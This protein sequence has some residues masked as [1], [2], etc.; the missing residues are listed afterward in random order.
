MYGLQTRFLF[1]TKDL[2]VLTGHVTATAAIR[3]PNIQSVEANHLSLRGLGSFSTCLLTS[4]E[5]GG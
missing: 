3:P 5:A 2:G 4:E 1:W